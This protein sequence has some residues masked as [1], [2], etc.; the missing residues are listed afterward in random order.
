MFGEVPR[1]GWH[2][3][4]ASIGLIAIA[5]LGLVAYWGLHI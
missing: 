3:W 1:P 4:A 2:T 5:V